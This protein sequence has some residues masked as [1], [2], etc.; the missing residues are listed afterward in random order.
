MCV[1][2]DPLRDKFYRSFRNLCNTPRTHRRRKRLRFES[3]V[4]LN[5]RK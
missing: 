5:V 4:N 2:N 3:V 1:C